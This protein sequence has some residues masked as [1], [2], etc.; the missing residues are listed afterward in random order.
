M[1]PVGLFQVDVDLRCP[2][3][4][5]LR[6]TPM[7]VVV[8]RQM[9]ASSRGE[10]EQERELVQQ[11]EKAMRIHPREGQLLLAYSINKS[12]RANK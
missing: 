2:D 11:R 12:R 9:Q 3:D 10:K 6:E 4:E 8:V 1:K 7:V 5:W